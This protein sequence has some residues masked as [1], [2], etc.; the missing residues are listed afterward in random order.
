MTRS[1]RPARVAPTSWATIYSSP[2]RGAIRLVTRNPT[3]TAGLICPPEVAAK[4]VIMIASASPW[5]KA[6]PTRPT[7]PSVRVLVIIDPAPMKTKANVPMNSATTGFTYCSLLVWLLEIAWSIWD[8]MIG[9]VL[10]WLSI[11]LFASSFLMSSLV[12][13]S[14]LILMYSLIMIHFLSSLND[15]LIERRVIQR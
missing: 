1:S 7:A 10:L 12:L 8:F 6:M 9:P 2:R 14:L 11:I 3:V 5:A 4:M 15:F 13:M